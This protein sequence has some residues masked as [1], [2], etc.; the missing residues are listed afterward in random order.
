MSH[1]PPPHLPNR[2]RIQHPRPQPRHQLLIPPVPLQQEPQAHDGVL[3]D[4]G[5]VAVAVA[6]VEDHFDAAVLADLV[7]HRGR[8]PDQAREHEHDEFFEVAPFKVRGVLRVVVGGWGRGGGGPRGGVVVVGEGSG[9]CGGVVLAGARGKV[10]CGVGEGIVGALDG[11]RGGS[12]RG[13]ICGDLRFLHGRGRRT[14][15]FRRC[16]R[17]GHS[18]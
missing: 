17:R 10:L 9:V 6:A 3:A 2:P 15:C 7:L 13:G 14:Q 5:I 8:F 11:H 18:T 16:G 12:W 4:V 1:N